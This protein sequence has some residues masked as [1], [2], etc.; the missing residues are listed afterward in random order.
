MRYLELEDLEIGQSYLCKMYD[1]S[2]DLNLI[3]EGHELF[4][5]SEDTESFDLTDIRY[6]LPLGMTETDE[7]E[8]DILE[9][10]EG[11]YCKQ[12]K[13][14]GEIDCC[15]IEKFLKAHASECK[16]YEWYSKEILTNARNLNEVY[17]SLYE[18]VDDEHG[19]DAKDVLK[20]LCEILDVPICGERHD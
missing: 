1:G 19:V 14:C 18:W 16:Y 3:Y 12:C 4:K 6:V 8:A 10:A 17:D 5:N 13:C 15:G 9:K 7:I 20:T 2:A 11:Y